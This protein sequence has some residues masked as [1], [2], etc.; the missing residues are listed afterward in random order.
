MLQPA[1]CGPCAGV[2]PDPAALPPAACA[3]TCCQRL[4]TARPRPADQLIE[5]ITSKKVKD[6][7]AEDGEENFREIETQV[8]A[9]SA[10]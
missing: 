9:V 8:L 3:A 6:I 10:R 4:S 1:C 5:Q 2:A 7:F